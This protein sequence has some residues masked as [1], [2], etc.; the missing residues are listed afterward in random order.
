MTNILQLLV[1]LRTMAT[2]DLQITMGDCGKMSTAS[3]SKYLKIIAVVIARLAPSHIK[4]PEPDEAR[5]LASQF[6]DIAGMPRVIGC[7]D[8]SHVKI[9]SPGGDN[10][11][12]Y[13]CRKGYMPINIQE[14]CDANM[15]FINIISSW[16]GSTHDARIF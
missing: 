3:V 10:V 9:I 4:F 2:G 6:H 14:I 1:A 16:L 12:V 11:E 8:G 13:R 15:K 7:V 5:S